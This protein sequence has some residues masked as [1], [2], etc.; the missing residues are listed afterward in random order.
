VAAANTARVVGD[1]F[2]MV[3]NFS[4]RM[5]SISSVLYGASCKN[6]CRVF[7]GEK[8]MVRK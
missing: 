2:M 3:V 5:P 6:F 1:F 4:C 8:N 7:K